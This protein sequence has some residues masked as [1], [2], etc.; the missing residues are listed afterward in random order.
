MKRDE[1]LRSILTQEQIRGIKRAI[2]NKQPILIPYSSNMG[3][4]TLR[5]YLRNLGAIVYEPHE[6]HVVEIH[7]NISKIIPRVL[8]T[9]ED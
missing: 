1:Y 9:I 2:S 6:M 4:S 3:K 7:K 5:E 8:D